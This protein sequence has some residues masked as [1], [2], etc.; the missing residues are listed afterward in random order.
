MDGWDLIKDL[1]VFHLVAGFRIDLQVGRSEIA[2][3]GP[4][5]R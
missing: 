5:I 3:F 1:S 4:D 2:C